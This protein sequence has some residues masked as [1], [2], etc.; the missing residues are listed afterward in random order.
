[1]IIKTVNLFYIQIAKF[2]LKKIL[3]NLNL[4]SNFNLAPKIPENFPPEAKKIC[5][6]YNLK[7][8]IGLEC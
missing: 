3:E 1:L 4:S 5:E 7:V 6:Y 2:S 8:K